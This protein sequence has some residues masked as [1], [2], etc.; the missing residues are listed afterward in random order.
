MQGIASYLL[1]MGSDPNSRN[2]TGNTPLFGAVETGNR[3]IAKVMQ[4][5]AKIMQLVAK[6]MQFVAKVYR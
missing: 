3:H 4:L 1:E 5:V 2:K 6:V